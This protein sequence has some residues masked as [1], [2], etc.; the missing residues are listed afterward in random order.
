MKDK[1]RMRIAKAIKSSESGMNMRSI[2]GEGLKGR[3]CGW[4]VEYA[5]REY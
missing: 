3:K 4:Q 5:K 1:C 2:P